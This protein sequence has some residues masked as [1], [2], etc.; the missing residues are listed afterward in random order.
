MRLD[1]CV[2]AG[3]AVVLSLTTGAAAQT[4]STDTTPAATASTDATSDPAT[5]A[6]ITAPTPAK[7]KKAAKGTCVTLGFEVNDY[8]KDGPTKDAKAL[9]DTYV[10]KWAAA[11]SIKT[12]K[13]GAKSVNCELF[14]DF[15]VFDEHTCTAS[16]DVCWQGPP[17]KEALVTPE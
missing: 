4:A 10:V 16:A 7:P 11:N 5:T 13:M 9:L 12:Y 6:T 2:V 15:G 3:F 14:L 1:L 17:K 8:G